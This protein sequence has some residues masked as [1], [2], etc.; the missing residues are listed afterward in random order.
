MY[1]VYI[2]KCADK[3]F[4]TGITSDL[5]KRLM[6]HQSGKYFGSYTFDRRPVELVYY[7]EF[8]DVTRAISMEKQLKK[9]SRAK[10]EALINGEFE[11]LPNLAKKNF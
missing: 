9:W 11:K 8:T 3:T 5:D 6:E 1:C 7:A 4:Y 10:K 2:L